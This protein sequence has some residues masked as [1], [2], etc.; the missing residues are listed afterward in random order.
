MFAII[1]IFMCIGKLEKVNS[2]WYCMSCFQKELPHGSINDA[3]FRD[4]LHEEAIVSLNPKMI[5]GIIKQSKYF[6]KKF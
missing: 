3:K 6:D 5:S 2:L 1:L 4:L